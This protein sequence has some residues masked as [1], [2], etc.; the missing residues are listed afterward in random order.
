M[1]KL[2]RWVSLANDMNFALQFVALVF[3]FYFIFLTK[4]R[5][6]PACILCEWENQFCFLLLMRREYSQRHAKGVV[7]DRPGPQ[8]CT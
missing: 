7:S 4:G 6:I 8:K 3:V 5:G 1:L 2:C